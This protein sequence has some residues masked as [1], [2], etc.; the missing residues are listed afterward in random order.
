MRVSLVCGVLL[1]DCFV[2][3]VLPCFSYVDYVFVR[4]CC[5]FAHFIMCFMTSCCISFRACILGAYVLLFCLP[6]VDSLCVLVI[7]LRLLFCVCLFFFIAFMFVLVVCFG[8]VLFLL[9]VLFLCSC[10]FLFAFFWFASLLPNGCSIRGGCSFVSF[11]LFIH[12]V[13]R[14]ALV[15]LELI[16]VIVHLLRVSLF[17]RVV[18]LF[19]FFRA[20]LLKNVY[21]FVI[22]VLCL[23]YV[24]FIFFVFFIFT[25]VLLACFF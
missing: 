2:V 7:R 14:F 8:L 13:S 16:F 10:L 5:L 6:I 1:R 4:G 3:N 15:V 11:I 23:L 22:V 12:I 18:Y 17:V 19:M 9:C 20:S 21:L 24:V 25:C